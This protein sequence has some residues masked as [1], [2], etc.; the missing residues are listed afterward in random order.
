M[1]RPVA[2]NQFYR[3]K[4]QDMKRHKYGSE[5]WLS[6]EGYEQVSVCVSESEDIWCHTEPQI[7]R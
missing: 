1:P 5:F 4:L 6:S 3:Q 7:T 2:E